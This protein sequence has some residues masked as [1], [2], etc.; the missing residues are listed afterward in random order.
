[1]RPVMRPAMRALVAVLT[2]TAV[3]LGPVAIPAATAAP[4]PAASGSSGEATT[5]P[6]GHQISRNGLTPVLDQCRRSR[7]H[8]SA[9]IMPTPG[10]SCI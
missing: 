6:Q 8:E 10:R 1:M 5:R 2:A 7:P 4:V 3:A 9:R